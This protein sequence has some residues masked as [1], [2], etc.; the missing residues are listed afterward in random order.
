M[1]AYVPVPTYERVGDGKPACVTRFKWWAEREA[2]RYNGHVIFPSYRYEVVREG[3]RWAVVA[4]Q[5]R[6]LA[7]PRDSGKP[8]R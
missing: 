2:R 4:F 6:A 3:K 8:S 5:N 7:S 1:R